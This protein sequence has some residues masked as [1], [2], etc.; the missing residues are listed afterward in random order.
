M[1]RWP[2]P[3]TSVQP[4]GFITGAVGSAPTQ[5]AWSDRLPVRSATRTSPVRAATTMVPASTAG[6]TGRSPSSIPSNA[7]SGCGSPVRDG[8]SSTPS[9][10]ATTKALPTA[11]GAL[12][13][14]GTRL[15]HS[16]LPV[17]STAD[18]HRVVRTATTPSALTAGPLVAGSG[19]VT[20][21][22]AAD[23]HRR[24]SGWRVVRN[25]GSAGGWS[26]GAGAGLSAGAGPATVGSA[27]AGR[28]CSGA[29]F[30]SGEGVHP[31]PGRSVARGRATSGAAVACRH[32]A[33]AAPAAAAAASALA[34]AARAAAAAAVAAAAT[35][36]T[37]F[38]S[39]VV[40]SGARSSCCTAL[41]IQW[42][43]DRY[44]SVR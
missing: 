10:T 21:H 32:A 22:P 42:S 5:S 9:G 29:G 39:S 30:R 23:G 25:G 16:A 14:S 20:H 34:A 15:C 7:G 37:A 12:A 35:C 36:S 4:S 18:T 1:R 41:T 11:T 24:G 13:P 3:A 2:A 38:R 19:V 17:T 27:P 33:T 26:A 6:A 43:K 28:G 31:V 40:A 8:S 44:G